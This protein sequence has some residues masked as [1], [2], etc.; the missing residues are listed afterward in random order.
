[1]NIKV[2]NTTP[3]EEDAKPCTANKAVLCFAHVGRGIDPVPPHSY[4]MG[5]IH[6]ATR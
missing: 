2:C 4:T 3:F 6:V 1:M 5:D